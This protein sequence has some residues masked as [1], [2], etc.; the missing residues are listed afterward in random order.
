M[1]AQAVAAHNRYRAELGIPGLTWSQTLA[2]HAQ[3]WADHLASIGGRS[4]MHSQNSERPGEGEN[5][6]MGTSGYYSVT[7]MVDTWGNEKQ[8]YRDGVFPN[9]STTG[10]WFQVGHYTQMIWRD[11]RE[12]GCARASAGG[13]D[14]FVCRYSPPGNYMGRKAY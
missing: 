7:Q 14:I 4:L 11:T 13:N 3:V 2:E 6:W 5:L 8:Y 1:A 9:V 10:S 12:V